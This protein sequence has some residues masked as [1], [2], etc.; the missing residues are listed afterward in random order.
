VG[1][2]GGKERPSI[3][4]VGEWYM[5]SWRLQ[6]CSLH[7]CQLRT[8]ELAP[9]SKYWTYRLHASDMSL[10]SLVA[11]CQQKLVFSSLPYWLLWERSWVRTHG[12]DGYRAMDCVGS[13]SSRG[14]WICTN[15]LMNSWKVAIHIPHEIRMVD[16]HT[17]TKRGKRVACWLGFPLQG[18]HRFESLWL[19]DMSISCLWQ[20]SRR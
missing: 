18:V 14:Q 15:L 3:G 6:G 11:S 7:L 13:S 5:E 2:V 8:D 20:S 10:V 12:S 17:Q 19:S 1:S 9:A 4:K 16:G